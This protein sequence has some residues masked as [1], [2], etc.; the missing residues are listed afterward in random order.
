MPKAVR[1][2]LDA[3]LIEGNFS[4]YVLLADELRAR[5][6]E[7]S[8]SGLQRYGSTLEQHL[9]TVRD[10]ALSM[11]M[12][13]RSMADDEDR[14]SAGLMTL[15]QAEIFKSLLA[16]KDLGAAV[17]DPVKRATV[18]SLIG[19]NA[20]ATV[21]A[22]IEAK[23]HQQART[24]AEDAAAPPPAPTV[25]VRFVGVPEKPAPGAPEG[26]GEA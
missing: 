23:R 17:S 10:T 18:L 24:A 20:A 22:S 26:A 11:Q 15:I 3:A 8:K 6:Y 16:V 2:W 12:L 4:G 9:A 25:E 19:K 5:G 13:D 21:R 14:K 7:V 1:D